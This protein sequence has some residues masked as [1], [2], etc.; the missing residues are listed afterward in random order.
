M[1]HHSRT[2]ELMKSTTF[3]T[4]LEL[5]GPKADS[6]P[7]LAPDEARRYC[8]RLAQRHYENFT[9]GGLVVPRDA[10][11]HVA[12]VYAYCRWADDLADETGNS[13]ESLSLLDWWEEQ[14][15]DCYAGRARHPVFVAL[16]ETIERFNIPRGPFADLLTA[17]RQDQ[18]VT[19]YECFEDLLGY[20]RN[21]ANP[22]GRIVL[23]LADCHE[24]KRVALSDSVCTGLQ[25]ANF[26]QDVARD[27]EMGRLYL[28]R[29]DCRR[30]EVAETV[31][32][33]GECSDGFRELLAY[34]TDRAERRLQ[35]GLPLVA[36]MPKPWRLS[37]ALFVRGG[38]EILKAIR[39]QNYDVLTC[40]PTVSKGAKLRL[41]AG[42]WWQLRWGVLGKSCL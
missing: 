13:S 20:C 14:L 35:E 37:I 30:F 31:L 27:W 5:Y 24:P 10:R 8:R 7:A 41:V 18:A 2:K 33:T 4:E 6:P 39:R 42:C 40:R 36:M 38:L 3:Q 26:W 21:S 19:R 22:V 12:N 29:E 17:F 15:D 11:A 16:R 9:V 25:L 32:D 34:E 1:C 28:P 23:C